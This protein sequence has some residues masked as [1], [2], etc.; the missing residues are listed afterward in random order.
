V[1]YILPLLL[2]LIVRKGITPFS[3]LMVSSPV[4]EG[5]IMDAE[6]E[7][8]RSSIIIIYFISIVNTLVSFND[9]RGLVGYYRSLGRI[10]SCRSRRGSGG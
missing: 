5:I 1:L 9:S 3:K 6:G 4:L 10:V 8:Y 2:A 7:E